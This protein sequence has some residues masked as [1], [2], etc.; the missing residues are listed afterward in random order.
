MKIKSAMEENFIIKMKLT[1]IILIF[2]RNE[3][4]YFLY[5]VR[6]LCNKICYD[7]IKCVKKVNSEFSKCSLKDLSFKQYVT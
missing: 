1:T 4:T 6:R 2:A 7:D 3:Y 5:N